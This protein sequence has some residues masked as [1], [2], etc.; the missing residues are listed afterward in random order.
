MTRP[1]VF[2]DRDGTIIAEK[3]YLADPDGVA[4][5]PGAAEAMKALR[6]AGYAIVVVTNQSGIARGLYSLDDYHAVAARLEEVLAGRGMIPD[7]THFCPHHPDQSGPCDCRKP[8]TGM[9]TR[10]GANL[11]LDYASSYFVGDKITDVLPARSLG[12]QGILVRTGYGTEH[13]ADVGEDVWV[14]DD[15]PAAAARILNPPASGV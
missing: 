3:A 8:E 1:A 14:V 9:Y 13:E 4:L 12:G 2:L 10:A 6:D 11:R 15:L 5:I 7:E